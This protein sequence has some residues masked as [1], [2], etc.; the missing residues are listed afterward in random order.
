M[1]AALSEDADP[2]ER[3]KARIWKANR[4]FYGKLRRAAAREI[5]DQFQSTYWGTLKSV[6]NLSMDESKKGLTHA[7]A[8]LYAVGYSNAETAGSKELEKLRARVQAL[9][10]ENK[11]LRKKAGSSRTPLAGGRPAMKTKAE[12]EWRKNLYD[13]KTG[14]P[15]D[16]SEQAIRDGRLKLG[17]L[18]A[19]SGR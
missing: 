13:P 1:Q 18:S 12:P 14:L 5:M 10:T 6:P 2:V 15:S 8:H 4:D 9:E 19:L 11:S 7:L 17:E 3:D 16:E